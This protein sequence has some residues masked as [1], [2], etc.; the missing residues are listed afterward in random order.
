MK[1]NKTASLAIRSDRR[2]QTY[3]DISEGHKEET[4]GNE[5]IKLNLQGE[6]FV[7]ENVEENL[8]RNL[9]DCILQHQ[10]LLTYV[11]TS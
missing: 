4:G 5:G 8:Q 2:N 3:T 1:I 10:E 9:R 7:Q 11:F 6:N